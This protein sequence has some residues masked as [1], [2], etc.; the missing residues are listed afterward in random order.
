[1]LARIFLAC[2]GTAAGAEVVVAATPAG[3]VPVRVLD[4]KALLAVGPGGIG[5]QA[6]EA[7]L[8]VVDVGRGY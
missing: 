1:M 3:G 4:G 8:S 2:L 6:G 5:T 7:L